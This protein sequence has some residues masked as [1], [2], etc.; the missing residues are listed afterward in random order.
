MQVLVTTAA[1]LDDIHKGVI[2][3]QMSNVVVLWKSVQSYK[4]VYWNL[5]KLGYRI[6]GRMLIFCTSEKFGLQEI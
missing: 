6:I 1:D 5:M 2:L 4:L 3:L